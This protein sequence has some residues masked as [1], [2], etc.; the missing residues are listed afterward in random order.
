MSISVQCSW[1]FIY[2]YLFWSENIVEFKRPASWPIYNAMVIGKRVWHWVSWTS[3]FHQSCIIMPDFLSMSLYL[4]SRF[5]DRDLDYHSDSSFIDFE[6]HK[7]WRLFVKTFTFMWVNEVFSS[8]FWLITSSVSG[9]CMHFI[10]KI[11]CWTVT[12]F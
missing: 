8:R 2:E 1:D 10:F 6:W 5:F 11:C 12:Y 7:S 9:D 3:S 4:I